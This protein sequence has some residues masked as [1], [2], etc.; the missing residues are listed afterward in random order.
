MN[1]DS[2][3]KPSLEEDQNYIAYKELESKLLET[4]LGK[5]VAFVDGKLVATDEDQKAL[6]DILH[7]DYLKRSAMVKQVG[8]NETID[9]GG[10]I[11][12]LD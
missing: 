4:H 1:K 3:R 9:L 7:K 6:F 5:W 8:D 2:K 11:E 10:V 12:V